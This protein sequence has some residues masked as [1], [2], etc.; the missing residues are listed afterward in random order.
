MNNYKKEIKMNP[1]GKPA[2]VVVFSYHHNNTDKIANAMA[3]ALESQVKTPRQ[4]SPEETTAYGL[5]GLGAGIDSDRHYKPL[6]DFAER[7]P[8]GG[9][10]LAFIFS[11]SG[12]PEKIFG[13]NYVQN[14]A[15]KCHAALREILTGKG[16]DIVGEFICAGFNTNSFLKW[17]G[18][19][20]K[21]RPDAA[22]LARAEAFARALKEKAH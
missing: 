8:P 3:A 5:L 15:A 18:G 14:Y 2:L 17:F 7:L 4:V 22:D 20:N 10:R 9:G 21:G 19:V 16:Y 13:G 11:T 12:I 6:L 1:D